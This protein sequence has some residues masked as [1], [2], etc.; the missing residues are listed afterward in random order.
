M[1]YMHIT[2]STHCA[3]TVWV[4]TS[5]L[6][7]TVFSAHAQVYIQ[8]EQ[9]HIAYGGKSGVQYIYPYIQYICR[10]KEISM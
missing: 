9:V 1:E 10:A 6:A 5:L 4:V 3:G 7:L 2:M 8:P